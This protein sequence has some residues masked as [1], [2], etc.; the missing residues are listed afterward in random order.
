[1]SRQDDAA[2]TRAACTASP[3]GLIPVASSADVLPDAYRIAITPH[4]AEAT[5]DGT[6][7]VDL[8]VTA[9]DEK[10]LTKARAVVRV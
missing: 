2:A 8:L 1:M 6:V 7:E 9:A 5:F 3:S 4:V 10:V